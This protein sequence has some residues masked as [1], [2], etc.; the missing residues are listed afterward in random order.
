MLR[1][2]NTFDGLAHIQRLADEVKADLGQAGAALARYR[3]ARDASDAE[4]SPA[5]EPADCVQ[6]K[7]R[8]PYKR[9]DVRHA[10]MPDR[11]FCFAPSATL[12]DVCVAVNASGCWLNPAKGYKLAPTSGDGPSITDQ[13]ATLASAG[14]NEKRVQYNCTLSE[15]A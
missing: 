1:S 14:M 5:P 9:E 11:M 10:Y 8:M 3:A 4:R 15:E 2:A 7:I 13:A 12:R 6:V